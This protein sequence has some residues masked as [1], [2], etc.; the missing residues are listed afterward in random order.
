MLSAFKHT[1]THPP[2][3]ALRFPILPFNTIVALLQQSAP[4]LM[5]TQSYKPVPRYRNI[6][7]GFTF[8]LETPTQNSCLTNWWHEQKRRADS[9]ALNA[10]TNLCEGKDQGRRA[11]GELNITDHCLTIRWLSNTVLPETRTGGSE[12]FFFLKWRR[13]S[14]MVDW[15]PVV[16]WKRR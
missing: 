13:S 14:H 8:L 15:Y 12:V 5:Y 11:G 1:E 3:N 6:I 4:I 16:S 9:E 2:L 10:H 7:Q